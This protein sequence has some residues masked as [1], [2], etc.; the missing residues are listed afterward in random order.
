M[1]ANL[2]ARRI[3]ILFG[4]H[5]HA[6]DRAAVEADLRALEEGGTVTPPVRE[7]FPP[8]SQPPTPRPVPPGFAA[9][10]SAALAKRRT[11]GVHAAECRCRC[12]M[13]AR[14]AALAVARAARVNPS[15]RPLVHL[16]GPW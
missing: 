2:E 1:S 6:H 12:C 10:L 4:H 7:D 8:P 9:K 15:A 16:D 14:I 13:D 3:G 11:D 5:A